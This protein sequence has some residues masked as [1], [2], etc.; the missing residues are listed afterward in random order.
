M[1][2]GS[3]PI[4]LVV[5]LMFPVSSDEYTIG[6]LC[7]RV[8]PLIIAA[9]IIRRSDDTINKGGLLLIAS[10]GVFMLGRV[11]SLFTERGALATLIVW[12]FGY[13]GIIGGHLRFNNLWHQ[14]RRREMI[15][16][17]AL[18]TMACL[19][20][21]ADLLGIRYVME[22]LQPGMSWYDRAVQ[23]LSSSFQV[24]DFIA[25]GISIRIMLTALRRDVRATWLFVGTLSLM[26]ADILWQIPGVHFATS[27]VAVVSEL[28]YHLHAVALVLAAALPVPPSSVAHPRQLVLT[29]PIMYREVT[30]LMVCLIVPA[31]TGVVLGILDT[32]RNW[33]FALHGGALMALIAG[34]RLRSLFQLACTEAEEFFSRATHDPLTGAVNRAGWDAALSHAADKAAASSK[35]YHVLI[36]DMDWFKQYNDT[37]G[38]QAGDHLLCDAVTAWEREL[39]ANCILA[40]LGGEEFGVLA[41]R[42]TQQEAIDLAKRLLVTVPHSQTCSIGVAAG[43]AG[44]VP[45]DVVR[46]ADQALYTAKR[47]GKNRYEVFGMLSTSGWQTPSPRVPNSRRPR[48]AGAPGIEIGEGA[49]KEPDQPSVG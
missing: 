9:L 39:P 23:L 14:G 46:R 5:L 43:K 3:T 25:F 48:S 17:A 11:V 7:T 10:E 45:T 1:V 28:L 35:S 47:R 13:I 29:V 8:P 4:Y 22:A 30:L 18:V 37:Y 38:H 19:C 20:V 26:L 16:D 42:S 31:L 6:L 15:Q 41:P 34:W 36:A 33:F 27:N 21:T 12:I 32:H 40:R 44:D 2:W 49:T 24:L